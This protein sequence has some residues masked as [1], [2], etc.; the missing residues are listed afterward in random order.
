MRRVRFEIDA[1]WNGE[2]ATLRREKGSLLDVH[3]SDKL[4]SGGAPADVI[5]GQ[6][7]GV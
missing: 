6:D 1:L 2:R 5:G 4:G 7:G 3:A